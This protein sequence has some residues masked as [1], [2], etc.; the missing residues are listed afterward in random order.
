MLTNPFT[1]QYIGHVLLI[2]GMVGMNNG[3]IGPLCNA[4]S[5]LEAKKFALTMNHIRFPSNQFFD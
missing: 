4:T 3:C 1:G 2:Q 5:K